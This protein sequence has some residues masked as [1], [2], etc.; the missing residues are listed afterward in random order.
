MPRQRKS[1]GRT[2]S[3]RV[4]DDFDRVILR[5]ADMAG[6]I[7]RAI[8]MIVERYTRSLE[9][10]ERRLED[11]FTTDEMSWLMRTLAPPSE[12]LDTAYI[13]AQVAEAVRTGQTEGVDGEQIITKFVRLSDAEMFALDERRR[14]MPST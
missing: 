3:F 13:S 1:N 5:Y 11:I 7:T 9:E 8:E 6:G 14:S 4:S 2:I 12:D 10:A